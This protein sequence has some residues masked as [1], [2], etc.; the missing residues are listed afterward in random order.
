MAVTAVD[1]DSANRWWAKFAKVLPFKAPL[2]NTRHLGPHEHVP[3]IS[4]RLL[5][6]DFCVVRNA[7]VSCIL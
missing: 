2:I 1:G 7:A 4:E 6:P 3:F 5:F